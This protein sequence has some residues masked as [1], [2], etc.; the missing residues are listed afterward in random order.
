MSRRHSARAVLLDPADRVLLFWVDPTRDPRG[1]G[2]WYLPGGGIHDGETPETA[3][4]RELL[5]EAGL[6]AVEVGPRLVHLTGVR[7]EFGGR[8]V[9]E[10]EWHL[11]ARTQ[12]SIGRGRADDNETTAVA[13]HCWWPV[14]ELAASSETIY[15]THLAR[16][17][18]AV[19]RDGPPATPVEIADQGA[20]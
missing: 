2:Y 9:E 6:E 19:L 10:D 4:R 1:H 17:L 18:E 11:L 14:A 5:E 3:V 13:A 8:I 20:N 12:A 15:P 7:F 16:V